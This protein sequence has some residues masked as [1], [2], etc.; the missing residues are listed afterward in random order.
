MQPTQ[1]F[2]QSFGDDYDR[3]IQLCDALGAANGIVEIEERMKDVKAR[4]G[5]YPQKK[6]DKNIK[7]KEYF[8][9]LCKHNIYDTLFIPH[10]SAIFD[11]QKAT[12]RL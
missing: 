8:E 12:L 6:W 9:K 7:L 10:A 3:L 2:G 11:A 4:Y 1:K 5:T